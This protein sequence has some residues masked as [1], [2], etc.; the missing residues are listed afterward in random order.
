MNEILDL[1]SDL[2]AILKIG[3]FVA[4]GWMIFVFAALELAKYLMGI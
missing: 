1:F 2:L 4:A 3:F